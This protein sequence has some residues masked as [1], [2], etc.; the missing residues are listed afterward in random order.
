MNK[1]KTSHSLGISGKSI[2]N[3]VKK[4]KKPA[5]PG[6]LEGTMIKQAIPR[7]V[8]NRLFQQSKPHES[9]ETRL[10]CTRVRVTAFGCQ[11]FAEG[12]KDRK[13]RGKPQQPGS[14]SSCPC[15]GHSQKGGLLAG[16]HQAQGPLP[17]YGMSRGDITEG[18]PSA[19]VHLALQGS[20]G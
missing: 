2:Y 20:V 19:P 9:K 11:G 15:A 13:P 14:K 12:E 7:A 6:P 17:H 3:S 10:S 4:P 16:L 8:L 1:N 5:D 18:C